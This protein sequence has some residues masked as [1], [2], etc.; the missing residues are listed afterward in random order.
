MGLFHSH[1]AAKFGVVSLIIGVL[2]FCEDFAL[3]LAGRYTNINIWMIVL[4]G[5]L[6]SLCI[7]GFFKLRI[8]K[9]YLL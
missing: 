7:A 5:A 6:F 9:K 1:G 4:A 8:V 3:I 2:H